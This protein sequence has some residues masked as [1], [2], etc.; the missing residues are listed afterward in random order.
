MGTADES[1]ADNPK[2]CVVNGDFL[3]EVERRRSPFLAAMDG[4]EIMRA[5]EFVAGLTE[6]VD[7]VPSLLEG[8]SGDMGSISD[9]SNHGDGRS[10]VDRPGRAF[11]VEADVAPGDR[12]AEGAASLGNSLHG[13]TELVEV[14]GLVGIAEIEIVGDADRNGSGAGKVAGALGNGNTG[15]DRGIEFAVDG[16]AVGGGGKDLVR[17]T[18]NENGRIGTG[19]NGRSSANHVVVLAPDPALASDTG[20]SKE[21]R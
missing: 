16:V 1:F 4:Q 15:T 2:K 21:L 19:K 14:L 3:I 20:M 5:A 10:G 9:G 11:V 13:G 6:E 8:L 17:L 7:L 12:D 18:D